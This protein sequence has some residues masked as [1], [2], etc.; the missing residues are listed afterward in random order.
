[1][2]IVMILIFLFISD[3]LIVSEVQK[4]ELS[5]SVTTIVGAREKRVREREG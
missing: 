4:Q 3:L 5:D 2:S 1:M